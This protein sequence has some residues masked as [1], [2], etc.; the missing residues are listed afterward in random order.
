MHAATSEADPA[1][2]LVDSS[3]L[4]RIVFHESEAARA[5]IRSA[6]ADGDLLFGSRML[7]L[8]TGR[9][10]RNRGVWGTVVEID[11]LEFLAMFELVPLTDD[12]V[13]AGLA[14][15]PPI[16]GADA[17]HVVTA[18]RLGPEVTT[19]THDAQM[20]RACLALGLP[21]F[22]PVTDDPHRPAVV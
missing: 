17:I 12:L 11:L 8:E 7:E 10:V 14:L 22:D 19:V 2:W 20:A 6:E 3:V 4:C 9:A 21:V 16:G 13:E 1:C 18:Q 15:E 5:W